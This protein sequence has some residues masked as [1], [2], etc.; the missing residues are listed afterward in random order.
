MK[1]RHRNIIPAVWALSAVLHLSAAGADERYSDEIRQFEAFVERQMEIERIPGLSIGFWKDGFTWAKGFGLA[2]VENGLPATE[3]SAYRLASNSKSMT[4]AAVL[5]LVER[6]KI[7]LDAEVQ[8]YVPFFPRKR[9]P[10]TVRLLLGHLGGISH[11]RDYDIEGHIKEPK[12]TRGALAIFEDFELIAE[13]GT[14][15]N[16]SSYGFNL[17]AAVV[18][19]AAGQ[20]FGEYMREHV[21][22]PLDMDHTVMDDPTRIIPNRVCGYRLIDGEVVNSEYVDISSRFGGGGKRS[23]ILDMLKYIRGYHEYKILEKETIELMFT[24]MATREGFYTNY[25]MGWVVGPV[26]GRFT[27]SHGGAQA[28]TR[29]HVF[30]VP[31]ADFAVVV[32]YNFEGADRTAFPRRLFTL[33]IGESYGRQARIEDA[34]ERAIYRGLYDTFNYGLAYYDRYRKPMTEERSSLEEAFDYVNA[35]LNR[36]SLNSNFSAASRKIRNG[37]HPIAGDAFVK[38]GSYVADRLGKR[39]RQT[40]FG[41][42]HKMGAARFFF[43]YVNAPGISS[44]YTF[45][46]A[47]VDLIERWNKEWAKTYSERV[48][49]VVITPDSDLKRTTGD[50]KKTFA[51]ASIVPDFLPEI[52]EIVRYACRSGNAEKARNAAKM[53][54]DLY[55]GS[56]EAHTLAGFVHACFGDKAAALEAFKRAREIDP[57]SRNLRPA[58]FNTFAYEQLNHGNSDAAK[59]LLEIGLELFPKDAGLYANIAEF[60]IQMGK[61]NL[62]KALKLDPMHEGA[63]KRLKEIE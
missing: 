20:P 32:A 14:R 50:L 34:V 61:A 5:Q 49:A 48:Q 26:N 13:P 25:G 35:C 59:R 51:G 41:V 56:P 9:W 52:N 28:E 45:D 36:D 44:P 19:G 6:G 58:A 53:A 7:D 46:E 15:Y 21:W 10:V 43:D 40:G 47:L 33:I 60:Y 39:P 18:E 27:V 3:K 31:S 63:W 1:R 29:T 12:D 55:G 22:D 2:D 16:Y 17:L 54:L 8:Q 11:Y 62:M 37:R 57:R 23:T 4:A 24:S 42:Y 38:V 30:Y